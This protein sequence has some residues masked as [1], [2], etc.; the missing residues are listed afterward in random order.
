MLTK[1]RQHKKAVFLSMRVFVVLFVVLSSYLYCESRP[2]IIFHT[3]AKSGYLGKV[4]EID[5]CVHKL[6]INNHKAKYR[7]PHTWA[8]DDD[9]EIAIF[10][11]K[12][13]DLYKKKDLDFWRE[14]IF[15][16]STGDY[17]SHYQTKYFWGK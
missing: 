2:T 15:L 6:Y 11:T 8:W 1:I 16:D 12:Y 4:S 5:G 9:D 17:M 3:Y 13:M 10:T 7:M 14:H